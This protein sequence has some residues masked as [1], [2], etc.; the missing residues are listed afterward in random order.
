MK[1]GEKLLRSCLIAAFMGPLTGKAFIT[2][3]DRHR[4]GVRKAMHTTVSKG[5]I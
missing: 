4:V 1:K 5:E 3:L 2:H